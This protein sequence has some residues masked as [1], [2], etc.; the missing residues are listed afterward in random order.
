MRICFAQFQR[1][2][3]LFDRVLN[4]GY[5]ALLMLVFNNC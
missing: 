5:Q 4:S 2:T 1:A 3:L